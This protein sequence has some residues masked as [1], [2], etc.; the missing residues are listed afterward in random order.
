M[1]ID[2][3][4]HY[5]LIK[6]SAGSF[7][8]GRLNG[9]F[10]GGSIQINGAGA[11]L[12]T[13]TSKDPDGS[14]MCFSAFYI[15]DTYVGI[16][17]ATLQTAKWGVGIASNGR[18]GFGDS[19]WKDSM[20]DV[21]IITAQSMFS[22]VSLT[23]YGYYM[24]YGWHGG[25]TVVQ[26]GHACYYALATDTFSIFETQG[27]WTFTG[28][29]PDS[30]GYGFYTGSVGCVFLNFTGDAPFKNS[31]PVLGPKFGVTDGSLVNS[32]GVGLS[33]FP[34]DVA[35]TWDGSCSYDGVLGVTTT[36]KR[37]APKL[38]ELP[39]EMKRRHRRLLR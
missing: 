5:V 16:N 15:G 2:L 8:G 21:T 38:P 17:Y 3:N 35:G 29:P 13:I 33:M 27:Y 20:V 12:T 34:G 1:S 28:T 19:T 18:I 9:V 11:A 30:F 37:K 10:G 23:G 7:V 31:T 39:E 32:G 6:V 4:R 36:A 22:L 25:V 26:G 14:A 24:D